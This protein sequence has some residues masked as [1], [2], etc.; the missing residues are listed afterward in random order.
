MSVKRDGRDTDGEL[1]EQVI[2]RGASQG[3]AQALD[4][5]AGV[6]TEHPRP[7]EPPAR[8]VSDLSLDRLS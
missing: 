3:H 5:L 2:K 6:L 7:P 1:P 4:L 8:R